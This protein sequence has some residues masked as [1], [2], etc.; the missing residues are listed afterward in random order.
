[1]QY[2]LHEPPVS[3]ETLAYLRLQMDSVGAQYDFTTFSSAIANTYKYSKILSLSTVRLIL[4]HLS[5]HNS[6]ECGLT[7]LRHY[8]PSERA[9][10]EC[11][12]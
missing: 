4:C 10:P 2:A 3:M 5:S 7:F 9:K 8:V 1:M 6:T 12:C 11:Q